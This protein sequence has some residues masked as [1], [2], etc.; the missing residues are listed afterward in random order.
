MI[1]RGASA[2]YDDETVKKA[3]QYYAEG[4]SGT[5]ISEIMKVPRSTV[6][7]WIRQAKKMGLFEVTVRLG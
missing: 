3:L 4:L 2:H 6:Y 1:T 5:Q 7:N